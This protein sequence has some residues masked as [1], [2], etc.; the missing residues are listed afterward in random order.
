[1][2]NFFYAVFIFGLFAVNYSFAEDKDVVEVASEA[3]FV[4]K[5]GFD[6]NDNI[7]VVL[8]GS[9]PNSCYTIANHIVE[10]NKNQP[11]IRIRQFATRRRDGVCAQKELPPHL[12]SIV[13][14]TEEVSVGS[15]AEGNYSLYYWNKAQGTGTKK[16]AVEKAPTID[17]DTFPYAATSNATV[18]DIAREGDHVRVTI[19]G[20]LTSGCQALPERI[21]V[22]KVDD[23][24]VVLPVLNI[25]K[26][27]LCT[28]SIRPFQRTMELGTP[29]QGHYLVHVRS[30]NGK[31]ISRVFEVAQ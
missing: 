7:T 27:V 15:L 5:S 3:A 9:L 24:Y 6:D 17:R 25:R 19:S 30:M 28:E 13:P 20:V 16:F 23:V 12:A 31:A 22:Q 1:M 26:N 8:H 11:E 4:P 14:F 10:R 29:D 21:N 2:K 18:R